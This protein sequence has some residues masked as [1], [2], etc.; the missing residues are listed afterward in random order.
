MARADGD[1][2]E[3]A[4]AMV[5]SNCNGKRPTAAALGS[6]NDDGDKVGNCD[7]D[8][9]GDCNG[10]G[11]GKGDNDK[12]RVASSCASNVQR[13][14]RGNT[15]PPP[16]WTQKKVHSP[17]LRHGGD[18]SKSVCSPSRGRVPDSSPWILFL[19]IIYNYCLVY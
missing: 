1:A 13:C 12:G 18:T 6:D 5:N 17:V 16:P 19:F 8:G 4:A 9:N 10:N 2:T 3:T 14:G 7:G 15:L 11:H